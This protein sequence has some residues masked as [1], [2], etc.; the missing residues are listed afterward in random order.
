[1]IILLKYNDEYKKM[2]VKKSSCILDVLDRLGIN[3]EIVIPKKNGN[4]VTEFDV[5]NEKDKLQLIFVK[6]GG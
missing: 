2:I 1:M 5:L 6:S 3:R 4:I